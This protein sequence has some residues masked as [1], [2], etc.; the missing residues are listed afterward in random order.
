M[1]VEA[2]NIAAN[3]VTATEINVG[4]LA[5]VSADMGSLTAG[6]IT[7]DTSGF[8]KGGQTAYDTGSGFFLGYDTAAYKFSIGDGSSQ[9]LTWDGT[10]LTI[11]GDLFLKPYIAGTTVEIL[12]ANTERSKLGAGWS[13]VKEF[14][15]TRFGQLRFEYDAKRGPSSGTIFTY[16]KVRVKQGAS[17]LFTSANITSTSYS[18]FSTNITLQDPSNN[19]VIEMQGGEADGS[20]LGYIKNTSLNNN[21]ALAETVITD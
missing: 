6:D 17:T 20:F 5:A 8:I 4:S 13:T 7:L 3:A 2:G 9:K 10:S 11:T 1:A 14:A 15:V 19:I 16:P 21:F 18:S 12:V